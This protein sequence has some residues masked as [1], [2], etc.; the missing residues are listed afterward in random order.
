MKGVNVRVV[1]EAAPLEDDLWRFLLR[2][3]TEKLSHELLG[4]II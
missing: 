1:A 3:L 4:I 2:W